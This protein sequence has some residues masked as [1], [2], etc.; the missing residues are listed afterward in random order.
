MAVTNDRLWVEGSLFILA[1]QRSG[2]H[3][4]FVGPS[5]LTADFRGKLQPPTT[6]RSNPIGIAHRTL[7]RALRLDHERCRNGDRAR[8]DPAGFYDGIIVR[9]GGREI[10][11]A[12][13]PFTFVAGEEAQLLLF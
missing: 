13:P 6:S 1:D 2:H 3:L 5:N 10:V 12:G 7:L 11:M 9:H 8:G 4:T